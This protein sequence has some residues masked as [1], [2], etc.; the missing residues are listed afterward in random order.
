VAIPLVD[1]RAQYAPLQ[2]ELERRMAE[3]LQSG[4]F[5]LGPQVQA[6]EE[7]AAAYLGVAQTIGVANGTDA[8]VLVLDALGIGPGDEVICPAFT[9]F[10]TAEA[11]ARRGATPVF[12]DIDAATLNLDPVDVA[13]RCGPRTKAIL[14]V[15]IFGCPARLDELPKGIPVVEDA[16]QAF[17]ATLGPKRVGSLGTAGTFSFFPSKTLFGLGDGGLVATS[18]AGLGERVRLLR[19]HG[20]RDK[21]TFEA[22]GYNSRL[23]EIQATALRLFLSRLDEWNSA[24]R[25]AAARYADLGLG[26][27]CELPVVEP[28]HVYHVYAVRI[29]ERERVMQA[30]QS[31]GIGCAAYY[32]TPLHLQPAFRTLG[33]EEG[34]LPETEQAGRDVLALPLWPSIGVEQQQEVVE[35]IRAAVTLRKAS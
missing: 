10:A 22:I 21:K 5:I 25:E 27:V 13:G 19:S 32:S 17:G 8:L 26:E 3:V 16:A 34:S 24:R 35:T 14:A 18:D 4:R 33:Y 1:V 6:F 2:A 31:S 28:G 29:P 9:F 15:H 23:D 30:L 20:S 7:E 12:A 11:I